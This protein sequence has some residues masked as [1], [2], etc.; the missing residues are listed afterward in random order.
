MKIEAQKYACGQSIIH[1]GE[2]R[3]K[4]LRKRKIGYYEQSMPVDRP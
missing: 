4:V 1:G 2:G 3:Q